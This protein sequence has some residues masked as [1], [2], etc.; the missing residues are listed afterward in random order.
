MSARTAVAGLIVAAALI[1]AAEPASAQGSCRAGFRENPYNSSKCFKVGHSPCPNGGYCKWPGDTCTARNRCKNR[2]YDGAWHWCSSTG[3]DTG[4]QLKNEAR[5][6]RVLAYCYR[7]LRHYK[8]R[9]SRHNRFV[10]YTN[11]AIAHG[12]RCSARRKLGK[13]KEAMADCNRAIKLQPRRGNGYNKRGSLYRIQKKYELAIQDY[14]KSIVLFRKRIDKSH[15][16]FNRGVVYNKLSRTKLAEK[17][18]SKAFEYNKKD[19]EPRYE[20]A[21][22]YYRRSEYKKSLADFQIYIVMKPKDY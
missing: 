12:N 9:L 18:F 6:T 15:A 14:T 13:F 8:Y 2:A 22:I 16:H 1:I 11:I 7:L 10:A 17:D 19:P 20:R 5:E 4:N 21:K 3:K